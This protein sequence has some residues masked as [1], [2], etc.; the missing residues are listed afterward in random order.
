MWRA[1]TATMKSGTLSLGS[2][3]KA[4]EDQAASRLGLSYAV[5]VNRI[6]LRLCGH[7]LSSALSDARC[8]GPSTQSRLPRVDSA[9]AGRET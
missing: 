8:E 7:S 1:V 2:R 9:N 5:G 6:D 4:F 3:L